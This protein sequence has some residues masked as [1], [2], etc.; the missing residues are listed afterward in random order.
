MREHLLDRIIPLT[1]GPLLLAQGK[2]TRFRTPKL[3]APDGARHGRAGEGRALSVLIAGDS[4][5]LGVGVPEQAHA[6]SGQLAAQL[7]RD[8]AVSWRLLAQS[9]IRTDGVIELL[10]QSPAERFDLALISV[11]GNDVTARM[12]VTQ[13]LV[14]MERLL[15]TLVTRFGVEHVVVSPVPPMQDFP[16]MPQ[17]LRWYIGARAAEYNRRLELQLREHRHGSLLS[18]PHDGPCSDLLAHD[19]FHPGPQ[20]YEIWGRAAARAIADHLRPVAGGRERQ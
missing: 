10:Q 15:L 1:L 19:G 2:Y 3:P 5:A 20:L 7:A 14:S 12:P 16:A 11:G 4:S 18:I 6:I 8:Y 17:P 13:W 9:G